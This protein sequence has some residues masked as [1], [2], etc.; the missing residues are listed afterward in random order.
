MEEARNRLTSVPAAD[1]LPFLIAH[2]EGR[3]REEYIIINYQ[4]SGKLKRQLYERRQRNQTAQT[5]AKTLVREC[6][7]RY[8]VPLRIHSD[9]GRFVDAKIITE[10]Y[11]ICVVDKSRTTPH[12]PMGNGQC[13]IYNRTMHGLLRTLTPAQKSKWPDHLPELTYALNVTP[14]AATGLSPF[15][16]MFGRVPRLP[17]VI[18]LH[19]E[20]TLQ[21]QTVRGTNMKWIDYHQ[22]KLKSAYAKATEQLEL[23]RANRK[24]SYDKHTREDTL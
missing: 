8:G 18:R 7:L 16:M 15:Y 12:H 24:A 14:H 23:D 21:S 6:F 5:V 10:L 4:Y 17:I 20:E 1:R 3:A 2:L 11:K 22:S 9:Q 13:E 19:N